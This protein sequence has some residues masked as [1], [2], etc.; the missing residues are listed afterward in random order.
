MVGLELGLCPIDVSIILFCESSFPP[1]NK[2]MKNL[3]DQ[4][5]P[6]KVGFKIAGATTVLQKRIWSKMNL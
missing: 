6:G 1:K 5:R 2:K 4:P 3:P